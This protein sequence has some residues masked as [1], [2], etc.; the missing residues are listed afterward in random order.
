MA[1]YV[2]PPPCPILPP[3]PWNRV[4]LIQNSLQAATTSSY[5]LYS[6]QAAVKC[7]ESFP[8]SE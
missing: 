2:G 5:A 7:P 1:I 8:E 6:S 4:N 3:R